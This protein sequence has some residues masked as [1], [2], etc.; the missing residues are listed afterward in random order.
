[1]NDWVANRALLIIFFFFLHLHLQLH[2][3]SSS[4]LQY[5]LDQLLNSCSPN[6]S[7]KPSSYSGISFVSWYWIGAWTVC[8]CQ[9][10]KKTFYNLAFKEN[11]SIDFNLACFCKQ[12]GILTIHVVRSV[13]L[14]FSLV[15]HPPCGQVI[16][17][18]WRSAGSKETRAKVLPSNLLANPAFVPDLPP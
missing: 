18:I 11:P 9:R 3:Y 5:F 6:L 12:I 16:W 7:M 2:I 15:W 17:V 4:Q 13:L 1:M 8:F 14:F 10:G